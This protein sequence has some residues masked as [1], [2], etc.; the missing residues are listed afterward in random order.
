M[1]RLAPR[2]KPF[3]RHS[4][5]LA[6]TQSGAPFGALMHICLPVTTLVSGSRATVP[7]ASPTPLAT[8]PAASVAPPKKR[9]IALSDSAG[10]G[11]RV[12]GAGAGGGGAS[13]TAGG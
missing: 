3:A 12:A 6:A 9:P 7:A 2:E 13:I 1:S 11:R 8:S 10:V 5:S 4:A